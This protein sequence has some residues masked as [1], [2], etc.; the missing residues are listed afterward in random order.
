MNNKIQYYLWRGGSLYVR[1]FLL[2]AL[3]SLDRLE[4]CSCPCSAIGISPPL[5]GAVTLVGLS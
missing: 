5:A 3:L 1:E 2:Q 4:G